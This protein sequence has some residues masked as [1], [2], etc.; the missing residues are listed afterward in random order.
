MPKM[1]V[2]CKNLV[3]VLCHCLDSRKLYIGVCQS[4]ILVKGLIKVSVDVCDNE[5]AL[6]SLLRNDADLVLEVEVLLRVY[7]VFLHGDWIV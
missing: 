2:A 5:L 4:L 3:A 6:E 7:R 1:S